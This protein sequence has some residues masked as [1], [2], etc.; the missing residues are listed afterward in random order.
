MHPDEAPQD[1]M[2][3]RLSETDETHNEAW[4]Q[5]LDDMEDIAEDRREDGWDVT[6]VVSARTNTTSKETSRDGNWGLMHIVPNNF[7]ERFSEVYDE[8]EFTEYL[9][10]GTVIDGF[11]YLVTEF[12]DPDGR[13]SVLV[14]S[15][16]DM[17]WAQ[18]M[19]TNAREED[20]L[21]THVR[22]IDGT[23]LGSFVHEDWKP[24]VPAIE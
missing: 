13:R 12:I 15:R 8:D 11:V 10:Y 24:L 3:A 5:T 21:Y 2:E 19:L 14:A 7:G 4:E 1:L 22:T 16:Y 6:T 23:I 20:V 18:G 17:V 9:A